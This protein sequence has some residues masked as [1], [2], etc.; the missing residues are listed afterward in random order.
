LAAASCSSAAPWRRNSSGKRQGSIFLFGEKPNF[1]SEPYENLLL[2]PP[3]TCLYLLR[4]HFFASFRI[5]Y[6]NFLA[7]L[8]RI[9]RSRIVP[10]LWLEPD[11]LI[12]LWIRLQVV[13]SEFV[14]ILRKTDHNHREA[15]RY[16]S[17]PN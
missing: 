13:R 3:L 15:N 8:R 16:R 1:F 2:F 4:V 14:K 11:P 10:V 17:D 6:I 5:I 7:V 12:N 9:N